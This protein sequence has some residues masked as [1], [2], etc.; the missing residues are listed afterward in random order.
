MPPPSLP[1]GSACV[2]GTRSPLRQS[3]ARLWCAWL[4]SGLCLL[5]PRRRRADAAA[6]DVHV[7]SPMP[8][9]SWDRRAPAR[10]RKPR[11][12]VAVPGKTLENWQRIDETDISRE[13]MLR[14]HTKIGRY[15][16]R[17][18]ATG[19]VRHRPAV[20]ANSQQA[21]PHRGARLGTIPGA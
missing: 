19:S 4:F 2:C 5:G 6:L 3:L 15:R 9:P 10:L 11:W 13:D 21:W 17:L 18:R 1:L 20:V 8:V 7:V 12:S 16:L 14:S